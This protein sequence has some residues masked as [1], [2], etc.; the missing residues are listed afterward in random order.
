MTVRRSSSAAPVSGTR[1]RIGCWLDR[2]GQLGLPLAVGVLV[3]Y[4]SADRGLRWMP[5]MLEALSIFIAAA[6]L[7]ILVGQWLKGQLTREAEQ[8]GGIRKRTVTL[9]VLG[10]GAA[11]IRL[12]VFWMEQP[13]PLT[14]LPPDELV[15]SFHLDSAQYRRLE[16]EMEQLVQRLERQP[17]LATNGS[18]RAL[19]AMDERLLRDVWSAFYSNAFALDQIRIFWEDWYRFDPSRAER[20]LFLRSFLLTFTAEAALFEKSVRLTRLLVPNPA[21]KTF[22]DA[23]HSELALPEHTFSRF[24]EEFLGARDEARV[25]AGEQYLR[26]LDR[27]LAA[28][29]TAAELGAEPLWRD[30]ERHLAIIAGTGILERAELTARADLQ[31]VKRAVR[32]TWYPTQKGIADWMGNVKT[33]RVGH[34]LITGEQLAVVD[35]RLEPGDIVLS[36][37]NWYLSN[38]G[39]PG[40]WPHAILSIG[41]PEE[42][43][44]AAAGDEVRSYLQSLTGQDLTIDQYLRQTFPSAWARY[45]AGLDGE[46]IELIEAVGE[47]VLL[48]SLSGAAGDYLAVL[49]PRLSQLAKVQ[50]IIEAFRHLDKP[51]DFDFDF[52]TDHALVC[53]EVV[54]RSYRPGPGKDGL[55]L[56]L[57]E[58]A[59]RLT[60][61]ANQIARLY[62]EQYGREEQQL[63]LV[64]FLDGREEQQQAVVA[65][66]PA[67]RRSHQRFQWDILQR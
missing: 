8:G 4:W 13:S 23:P 1:A 56:P 14:S 31:V 27:T 29:Q 59:G 7:L 38:V 44:Q 3:G 67:F 2:C 37:K 55:E 53:T 46:P 21:V 32:R 50:A 16:R 11:L 48:N 62:A 35:K 49:R 66:E 43:G 9:L 58:L 64:Y 45:H 10:C 15:Q 24:R 19:T 25:I 52:A 18:Y 54:W 34:Y 20:P 57:V 5:T 60:L 42:L 63:D 6:L 26:F 22:L 17:Q 33:R 30:L 40:F 28:R 65:D 41:D 51:Y 47:G 39:L 61:P 36:R 12:G